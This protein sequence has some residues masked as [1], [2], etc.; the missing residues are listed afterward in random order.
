MRLLMDSHALIWYVDQDNLLSP[1]AHAAISD[2]ANDL[3]FSAGSIWE[4]SIK[5]GLGK[6]ALSLPFSHWMASAIS[7][8]G[9]TVL[10]ITVQYAAVQAGL[11]RHHGDPFDRLLVAHALVEDVAIVSADD[12]MDLYGIRRIW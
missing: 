9:L 3:L 6:L 4:I 1:P 2:A 10:P 7:D 11:P 12:I 8:L 5:V